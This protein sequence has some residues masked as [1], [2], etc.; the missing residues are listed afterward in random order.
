MMETIIHHFLVHAK[1]RPDSIAVLDIQGAY[2]YDHLNQRSAYLAE[3]ILAEL[4]HDGQK[5]GRI[6]LLLP[7]T[8]DYLTSLLSVLRA[9]CAAVPMDAEYPA[10]RVRAMLMDVGCSVCITTKD[11]EKELTGTPCLFLEDIFPDGSDVPEADISLDYSSLD[12]EGLILYTSGSTGKPKGVIHRQQELNVNPE[13]MEGFLPLSEN[14]RTLCI[15]GFSFI[16]SLIDLTLPLF[17]GGSVYIANEMERKNVDMIWALFSKRQI[18]GMFLPPQMYS[19]MRKLHGPL[20]LEYVLLSGEKAQV[21]HTADDPLVYEFYGASESPAML[22]HLMGEGDAHSLGKPCRGITAYLMDDDG[23]FVTEPGLIGEL[24]I[25]SPYMALGYHGLPEETAKKFTEDPSQPG[26]RLFHTGDYM[27]WDASGDLIFHGRKDH[28]VKIRGYRVELDEV[29]RAAARFEG[30]TEAAC[31]PVH[32]NGGDHI[33]CYYTGQEVSKEALKAFIGASLPEYMVPEYC[34][35]LDVM[36]RNDR[37]KVDYPALRAMEIKADEAEYE[38]PMTALEESICKAFEAALDVKRVSA[39]ADFFDLGGTSL[40]VAVL[41]SNLD[42][43]CAISFQDVSANP[44]PRALAAFIEARQTAKKPTLEMNRADYPLTRTQLGIYLESLTG[45]SKETYTCSY[46]A[47]AAPGITA[48]QLIEAARKVIEAHPGMRYIIH[49]DK[50]GMPRMVMRPDAEISIPVIEGTEE[51]RLDFMQSF[52]PVVPMM[53]A[54]LLHLAVYR[55]PVRCYLAIKSHLIFFDGTAISLFIS[56]MNR[57]LAGKPLLGEVYTIQQAALYEEGL[58]ADGSHEKAKDYYLN[59]FK[60][61][62][63]VPALSGDLNGPLTPGVS[64]NIRWEPGTLTVER[65]KA[66][67]DKIHISESS[68]FMGAMAL[69]LGKYLNSRHVSFSTVYNGRP[70]SEM[71]GTIGTLIK[72]IPVYGNLDK[73]QAVGEFLRSISKQIFTTMANDIYSFDEVLKT[74]PVNEDV[75]FIYQGD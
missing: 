31:V 63:D 74:C 27:A 1:T 29:R 7:R 39:I 71:S 2:T 62:E 24:C 33:C 44:T 12:A 6:A 16:A 21:E 14:T 48:E 46:L 15:A 40:S 19:V 52:M 58:L 41:I 68:F 69:M 49:A 18:T 9:G 4:S 26:K 50:D 53:D 13:T 5:Q 60:A 66:F 55:T 25:V 28:M 34:V 8:K 11:R 64:E 72:R 54:I 57:A 65:V 51:G 61:A 38:P 23:Q 22:M 17:F 36:P 59:L 45:G 73:D 70:L 3:K 67:C 56:E 32:V 43:D 47:Q 20:P 42:V 30:I 37:N 35:H 10:E 75:E